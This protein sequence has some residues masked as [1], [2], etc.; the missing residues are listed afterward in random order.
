VL[1]EKAANASTVA[2][3]TVSAEITWKRLPPG[4]WEVIFRSILMVA[5]E[6]VCYEH[7]GQEIVWLENFRKQLNSD[8]G[9]VSSSSSST[10]NCPLCKQSA[11]FNKATRQTGADGR[12]MYCNRCIVVFRDPFPEY[13]KIKFVN[14]RLEPVGPAAYCL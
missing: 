6:P 2:T 5:N 7:F 12:C 10:N 9:E 1:F 3:G 11:T 4:G 13:L 14:G 8:N